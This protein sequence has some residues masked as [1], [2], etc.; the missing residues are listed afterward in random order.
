MTVT[1]SPFGR[2][3]SPRRSPEGLLVDLHEQLKTIATPPALPAGWELQLASAA[4]GGDR[5]GGDLIVPAL[6]DGGRRLD[7]V[8]VD[9]SG[10]GH[11]AGTRALLLAGAISGLL[12][13]VGPTQMFPALNA[14]LLRTGWDDGFATAVHVSIELETGS[15]RVAAAGHP[16]PVH[17]HAGSGRW[18][19]LQVAGPLLGVLDEAEWPSATGTLAEGDTLLGYTDGAVEDGSR[20]DI[21]AGLDRL[22]GVADGHVT[23]G[24]QGAAEALLASAPGLG[25]DDVTVALCRRVA[26]QE[27]VPG[28]GS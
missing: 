21:D 2:R 23:G 25:S 17:Y 13:V 5:L 1:T 6:T 15:F 20:R 3:R 16:P 19:P 14:H 9:V 24:F 28:Q 18:A 22:L 27:N 12:G 8:L 7:L 10:K 11:T 4:A 26:T